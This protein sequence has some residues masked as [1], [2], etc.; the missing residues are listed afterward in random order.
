MQS[1]GMLSPHSSLFS[2]TVPCKYSS[3]SN[4]L[5]LR[6]LSTQLSELTMFFPPAHT[7]NC[8]HTGSLDSG[9]AEVLHVLY[10]SLLFR[11]GHSLI[12]ENGFFIYFV[13]FFKCLCQKNNSRPWYSLMRTSGSIKPHFKIVFTFTKQFFFWLKYD[14]SLLEILNDSMILIQKIKKLLGFKKSFRIWSMLPL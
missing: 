12:Y 8:L 5:E 7:E 2:G 3:A 14:Y 9:G 6:S 4:I 11:A 1:S 13:K 10:L